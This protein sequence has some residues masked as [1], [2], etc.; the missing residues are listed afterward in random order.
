MERP[1]S[2][3]VMRDEVLG[4]RHEAALT[5][6]PRRL[7]LIG[8]VKPG[9]EAA[10]REIQARYPAAAAQAAGVDAS[11]A[12]IGSGYFAMMLEIDAADVQTVLA[13]YLNDPDVR[14]FHGAL[15]LFVEGLPDQEWRLEPH[16]AFHGVALTDAP[17]FTAAEPA[18]GT[19]DLPLA[20]S[21]YRWRKGGMPDAGAEPIGGG[22]LA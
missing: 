9:A 4:D 10:V 18:R 20:A 3:E 14:A 12:F 5:P 21:M 13:A 2:S 11:E 7:L 8:R 22:S 17:G 19:A 16:D 15:H 1:M 6:R